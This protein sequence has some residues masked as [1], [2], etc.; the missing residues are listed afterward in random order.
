VLE[1]HHQARKG[2]ISESYVATAAGGM[3]AASDSLGRA[4]TLS[5][6]QNCPMPRIGALVL[7]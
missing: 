3:K 1:Q 6:I 4:D 2:A 7:L 5:G